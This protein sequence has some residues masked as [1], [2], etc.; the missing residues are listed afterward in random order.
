MISLQNQ[1]LTGFAPVSLRDGR[2]L[3]DKTPIAIVQIVQAENRLSLLLAFPSVK[4]FSNYQEIRHRQFWLCSATEKKR[5]FQSAR[6]NLDRLALHSCKIPLGCS[7]LDFAGPATSAFAASDVLPPQ[8]H[9]AGDR[10]RRIGADDDADSQSQSK[11]PQHF[12]AE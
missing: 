10:N 4:K 5:C 12:T 1:A 2:K 7:A 6:E 8:H 9:R 11:A 3:V